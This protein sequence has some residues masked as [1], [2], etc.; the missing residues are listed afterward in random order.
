MSTG[1]PASNSL[2]NSQYSR[3]G[4][5]YRGRYIR[6][7]QRRSYGGR[8]NFRSGY[9]R[10]A[11]NGLPNL[12]GYTS[13]RRFRYRQF[14]SAGGNSN[15]AQRPNVQSTTTYAKVNLESVTSSVRR[16]CFVL[17]LTDFYRDEEPEKRLIQERRLSDAPFSRPPLPLSSVFRRAMQSAG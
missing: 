1:Y 5:Y 8:A 15:R 12:G 16:M 17:A 6:P 14:R 13:G 3:A 2:P 10:T 7:Y 11:V 9:R 4:T